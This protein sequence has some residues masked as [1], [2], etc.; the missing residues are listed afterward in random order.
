MKVAFWARVPLANDPSP[1]V[2]VC[3]ATSAFVQR[4]DEPRATVSVCGEKAK[5][6]IRATTTA[7]DVG[8]GVVVGAAV[9]RGVLVGVGVG[10]NVG[11]GVAVALGAL[12]GAGAGFFVGTG[13][14]GGGVA[15]GDRDGETVGSVPYL[16]WVPCG[17]AEAWAGVAGAL[18]D[19]SM[20][21]DAAGVGNAAG[22]PVSGVPDAEGADV[23]APREHAARPIASAIAA[24]APTRGRETGCP[25]L[26][27]RRPTPRR[28]DRI[29]GPP[30]LAP[31]R[32]ARQRV[33]MRG[34]GMSDR[35]PGATTLETRVDDIRAVMDAVGS[36]R[37]AGVPST[38]C[39]LALGGPCRWPGQRAAPGGSLR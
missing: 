12:V 13:V 1:A 17:T 16:S 8:A 4:T 3:G 10:A 22:A 11:R 20:A 34:V 35:A 31:W 38:T 32:V 37:A 2:T 15:A 25:E 5:S 24:T 6:T 30:G 23:E 19:G 36:E 14:A 21:A 28:A 9:G 29:S 27:M 39:M 33:D 26:F 18:A 7:L